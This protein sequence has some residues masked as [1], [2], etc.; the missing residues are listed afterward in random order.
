MKTLNRAAVFTDIHWGAKANSELHNND[1]LTFIKWFCTQVKELGNID[2]IVFLGDYFENRSALNVATLNAAYQGAKLVND[3]KLPVYFV[4]GNHDLY[5][6]HT[7]ELYSVVPFAEFDHYTIVDQPIFFPHIGDGAL[8]CPYLFPHEYPDLMKYS[9]SPTWW[10][11]FE[12]KGFVVTGYNIVMPT[13]PDP[14]D[15]PGPKHIF[16]GH[17]HKR[18]SNHNVTYIGNTFPTNFSDAGDTDR[19]M[20][21]YDHQTNTAEFINW[22]ECPKYTKTK[23]T[24]ILDNTVLIHPESRVKCV[25]DVPISFE[26]ST[27]LRQKFIDDFKLREFSMEESKEITQALTDTQSSV[28]PNDIKLDSVDDLVIQMLNDISTE[29]I[30]NQLLIEQ[31]QKLRV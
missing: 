19:G 25:I 11:H 26:E 23:L 8:F 28:D 7:R 13:G 5:H 24:D 9:N 16:S 14:A 27:Y 31:Y 29:H 3:L 1:C 17:F 30:D 20:M 12:F 2:H 15:F 6:R 21:V 18:Q 10:G 4:I 22:E